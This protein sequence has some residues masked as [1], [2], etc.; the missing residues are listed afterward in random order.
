MIQRIHVQADRQ[1]LYDITEVIQRAVA[2]CDVRKGLCTLYVPH[3][4]AS[5]LIQEG[6][7]PA[8]L[9]DLES[10]MERHVPEG[11]PAYTH[12]TEG[13][14]DPPSHIRT[15]LTPV[16]LGIPI[17]DGSLALGTWQRL[18]LWEH[19]RPPRRRTVIL[20]IAE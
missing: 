8:V 11:D 16:S 19:R 15:A 13:P 12:N 10:W 6:A 7:D 5:L 20:H 3:T 9:R 2:E 18:F 17:I 4:S 1:G 14:D